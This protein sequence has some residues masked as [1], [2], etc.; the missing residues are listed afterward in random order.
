MEKLKE[1]EEERVKLEVFCKK[2][3]NR[4]F[5]YVQIIVLAS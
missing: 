5:V 2:K 3:K 4:P 1:K